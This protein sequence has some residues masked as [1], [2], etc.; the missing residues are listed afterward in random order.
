MFYEAT[1]GR[2]TNGSEHWRGK[3][4]QGAFVSDDIEDWAELRNLNKDQLTRSI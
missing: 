3:R 1:P 2:V 4:K